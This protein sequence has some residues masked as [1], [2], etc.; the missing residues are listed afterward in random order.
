MAALTWH[1]ALV[2]TLKGYFLGIQWLGNKDGTA[3]RFVY[4][5]YQLRHG[6]GRRSRF[7][8]SG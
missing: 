1:H 2:W 5:R 4:G 3:A 8:S 6:V 7:A